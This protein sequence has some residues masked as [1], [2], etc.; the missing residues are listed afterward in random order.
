V[1]GVDFC[2][3]LIKSQH[4]TGRGNDSL[5]S[6]HRSGAATVSRL[7]SSGTYAKRLASPWR[8]MF[9]AFRPPVG[10][11]LPTFVYVRLHGSKYV[12]RRRQRDIGT[13]L[14]TFAYVRLRQPTSRRHTSPK[15]VHS[16]RHTLVPPLIM[17][18]NLIYHMGLH[19]TMFVYIGLLL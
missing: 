6:E 19:P 15:C 9:T 5:I 14:P 7:S 12:D 3:C 13:A 17:T 11:P 16:R 10:T 2:K 8:D 4:L 18:A 1:G